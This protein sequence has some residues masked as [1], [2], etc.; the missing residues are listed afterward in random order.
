MQQN[1]RLPHSQRL[2]HTGGNRGLRSGAGS[3][4]PALQ[5]PATPRHLRT[6]DGLNSLIRSLESDWKLGLKVRDHTWS[7]STSTG[8]LEDKVFGLIKRLHYSHATALER[9]LSDFRRLAPTWENGERLRLLQSTLKAATLGSPVPRAAT[10]LS[11]RRGG[12]DEAAP[13]SIRL[14]LCNNEDPES[15]YTTAPETGSPTDEEEDSDMP[16]SPTPSHRRIQASPRFPLGSIPQKRPS[17]SS[18]DDAKSPKLTRTAK[19][20]EPMEPSYDHS[21]PPTPPLFKKPS[22]GM[23]RSFQAKASKNT[24]FESNMGA[25][26][27]FNSTAGNT[28]FTSTAANTSFNSMFSSQATQDTVN[29][30]FTSDGDIHYPRLTRTSSTTMGSLDDGDLVEIS[31]KLEQELANQWQ[32]MTRE[33]STFGS[34]DEDGLV[35]A[36]F[37]VEAESNAPN[38]SSPSGS[39]GILPRDTPNVR[40][41]SSRLASESPEISPTKLPHYIRDLPKHNFFVEDIPDALKQY[42]YFILFICSRI[43]S[44][45]SIPLDQLMAGLDHRWAERVTF[46]AHI[47]DKCPQ[48]RIYE[49]QSVWTAEKKAH[50]G[51]TFKGRLAFNHDRKSGPVFKLIL[52]GIQADRS[53]RFQRKFGAD[54]FLYLNIPSFE[55]TEKV[56]NSRFNR[57]DL[58]NIKRQWTDWF[59]NDHVFLGRKWRAFHVEMIKKKQRKDDSSDKRVV[60]FAIEGHGIER[61][62]TVGWMIN[63]FFPFARNDHQNF[64][65]AFAR[66]DLGLSRTTPTF[67]FKPSQIRYVGD[68]LADGAPE[69]QLFNDQ[70]LSWSETPDGPQVMNDG[71]SLMS[72]GAALEIWRRYK[73]KSNLDRNEPMPCAFQ[74]RIGGAKGMWVVCAEAYTKSSTDLDLWIEITPSQLKFEPHQDDLDDNAS[75]DVHRLTFEHVQHSSPPVRSDLHLS[76]IP[77]LVDRGVQPAVIANLANERLDAEREELMEVLKAPVKIHHWVHKE[78]G[79]R[80]DELIQY[81]AGLPHSLP[82]KLKLLLEGGFYPEQAPYLARILLRFLKQQQIWMEQKLRIPLGKT[83]NLYGIA[84]P[85]GVLAPGEIHVQ[86][87][88]PFVDK[89]SGVTYRALNG[90]ELLVARNPACRR[91]DIQKVR[92]SVRPE[93]SHLPDVVVFS[94]KGEFP[95]AGK[96]QGGDYDGDTFWLC[97]ESVLVEPFQNAPAPLRALD[98]LKY[99]IKKD[100]RTLR[101]VMDSSE[102]STVDDLLREVLQFRTQPSLLGIVTNFLDKQSYKENQIYSDTLNALADMHD[103]LVDAPKQAYTFTERDWKDLVRYEL[104][105]GNPGMPRYKAAMDDCENAKEMGEVDKVRQKDYKHNKNNILDYLYFDIVQTHDLETF[106]LVKAA[107]PKQE[108]DDPACRYPYLQV[109]KEASQVIQRELEIL[110]GALEGIQGDWARGMLNN[111]SFKSDNYNRVVDACYTSF[112]SLSPTQPLHPDLQAW[113]HPYLHPSFTLWEFIRASA[114]YTTYPERQP[115]VWHMAGKELVKLKCTPLPGSRIIAGNIFSNFK[116][117][118]IKKPK[119]EEEEGSDDEF[120]IAVARVAV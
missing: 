92:C 94:S 20:K 107:H 23:A 22:L 95:L 28:S 65:K 11:E 90:L 58:S 101:Q 32:E 2:G 34:I 93:L 66:L 4:A 9:A 62:T 54:R 119:V 70:S 104:R 26:V 48:A 44:D 36:S 120:A 114:L 75:Y 86:F 40:R 99:G 13:R 87:S 51:Y 60:L 83:T 106:D 1:P 97:W 111:T 73:K 63:W 96:L 52:D 108:D 41:S 112:R 89:L 103:L 55:S 47:H 5:I 29:T 80:E 117:K 64:C 69:D 42:P 39:R 30:S 33:S 79:S 109:K 3:P 14:Q 115:F 16:P 57:V 100:K 61:P 98:P 10:P 102:L 78:S 53:C 8:R 56:K 81:Q 25:S 76:F 82:E 88:T 59:A 12:R 6:G 27:S 49:P 118:P 67:T 15:I 85:R 46:V 17:Q 71:C 31:T 50:D 19:A 7:P 74:G 84:D 77:I 113:L 105:C 24:S 43:A 35:N 91:S 37:G 68:I 18:N 72:V 38:P 45:N 110:V 116:T 21:K